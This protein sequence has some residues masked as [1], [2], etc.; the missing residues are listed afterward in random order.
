M[1]DYYRGSSSY[2]NAVQRQLSVLRA[3]NIANTRAI[4]ESTDAIRD[5]EIGIR[6]DIRAS[7]YTNLVMG[8]GIRND[9]RESTYANLEMGEGIRNDIRASAHANL[10]MGMDIRN[11]VQAN[12]NAIYEMSAGLDCAI[13]EST[14]S[15][16]ASQAMLA[17]TFNQN[18][19]AVNNTLSLGFSTVSAK[20]DAM[21]DHICSKLDEIHDILNNPLLTASRE[22]YRRALDDYK[23]GL[24]E[25]A[26]DACIGAVEKNRTDTISWYL[27][28]HIYLF[29]AGKFSNVINVDKAEEA[30]FNA[31]KYI[32]YDLGKSDEANTLGSEIYY[33]LGYARLI[34]SNDLL[35]EAKNA[36]SVKKLEEA[37]MASREA[38][39]LSA[40][41]L[42]AVY[43]Q[44]KELHFLG[45]DDESLQLIEKLIRTDKK[46]AVRVCNDKNF[47][48]LWDRINALI[49]ALRDELTD[50][51]AKEFGKI[52]ALA[53]EGAGRLAD[54]VPDDEQVREF[55]QFCRSEIMAKD[56]SLIQ[57]IC[58]DFDSL[59]K[60][61]GQYTYKSV[62]DSDRVI[63]NF[64]N[65]RTSWK[66]SF[67]KLES[68]IEQEIGKLESALKKENDYFSVLDKY[69]KFYDSASDFT[70]QRDKLISNIKPTLKAFHKKCGELENDAKVI[71]VYID[72]QKAWS[73]NKDSFRKKYADKLAKERRAVSESWKKRGEELQRRL[74]AINFSD[75]QSSE[76]SQAKS[77]LDGIPSL[78][79]ETLAPFESLQGKDYFFVLE[80]SKELKEISGSSSNVEKTL[81]GLAES[82][83][84]WVIEL[85]TI[86]DGVVTGCDKKVTEIAIPEGVTEI[87]EKAFYECKSL[88]SITI[89]NSVT[90]IGKEAF[91]QCESLSKITIPNSV[92]EIGESAF[93]GCRS[94]ASITIPASVTEIGYGAFAGCASL[95]DITIPDSVTKIGRRA[96]AGCASLASITIPNS[97]TKID[98][99]AFY[100]CKSLA[101]ITIPNSVTKIDERAFFKCESLAS[102]RFGGTKAQWKDVEKDREWND[103]VPTCTVRCMDGEMQQIGLWV[104]GP[105]KIQDGVVKDCDGSATEVAI[106]EGVTKIGSSAFGGCWSLASITIPNGVT[107]IGVWA[108]SG[109]QSLASITIP[110]S[111]T[112]IGVGAFND[113]ESLADIR[114]GGTKAQWKAVE[115]SDEY[116]NEWHK[117]VPARKVHCTDK[118]ARLDCDILSGVIFLASKLGY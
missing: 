13:R 118:D 45:R 68:D 84:K 8:E 97:V 112:K 104:S 98:E 76:K 115:K 60:N 114:F 103:Y 83:R 38:S 81:S 2:E 105:L 109:C 29:G 1:S 91:K 31:A 20:L 88:A 47:E 4:Y 49:T 59:I 92:T 117:N 90:E 71:Q 7:A 37:E 53:R 32:D 87:G 36:D 62:K 51:L 93:G 67:D 24:Y 42:L 40:E 30:F 77:K 5:A 57:T 11:D 96:F 75:K 102:I 80:K 25:E 74:A 55:E 61:D 50:K 18:F 17:Q 3:A 22:L 39:R 16:V 100:E 64:H 15:I 6:N 21:A 35:V 111:V 46:Y 82:L 58:D 63:K 10:A 54:I 79:E 106:P 94:L 101:S 86:Q 23:R 43:E 89:P 110:N 78:I 48:S 28:G 95:A 52:R 116:K 19:N 26:M 99:S 66:N 9:I 70:P 113:C 72:T 69:N 34:K 108:F 65:E 14:Y 56:K 12:T 107:K 73:E 27:L 41:N 85:L 33:Y 44:A